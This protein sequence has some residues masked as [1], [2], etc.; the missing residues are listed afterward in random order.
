MLMASQKLPTMKDV[1]RLAGVSIQTVSAIMNG[2][3]GI[4]A[5]TGARVNAA[6]ETLG[7]RPYSVA[8]SLR[9]RQ[10]HTLALIVSDINNPSFSMIASAAE[11]VA[12]SFGYHLV[13]FNTHDDPEREALYIRAVNE[14]WM[15]GVLFVAA[16]DPMTSLEALKGAGIPT[17]AV[18]RV[19]MGYAGPAVTL[20]NRR[21][22]QIAAEYLLGLGHR[23]IAH[24]SGPLKLLLARERLAGYDDA[25]R[26]A[27]VPQQWVTPHG[28]WTC[29]SGYEA[30]EEI[31]AAGARPSAV[32][33]A[34]DRM[35]IGAM[36]ALREGGLR[37]PEDVSV[38][39]LDDIEL[40]AYQCPALTTVQQSFSEMASR[41]VHLLMD[42]L[43][44]KA[45]EAVQIVIAPR[46]VVRQSAAAP[47][48]V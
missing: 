36:H 12:H 44:G 25:L 41:S 24:I 42:L 13:L 40:A 38:V 4:T 8:R 48:A 35:A 47:Q 20:D 29:R 2:K 45:P 34:N 32:F 22:G 37:V 19:P 39:G 7:Y 46:L 33:A 6:I 28:N 23:R 27:D 9:T 31:L 26:A 3:P 17:V 5:E 10:T 18:D 15:D 16:G 21:P 14:R 30:M 43:T 11:D 1:A